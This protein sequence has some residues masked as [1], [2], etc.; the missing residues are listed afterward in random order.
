MA[1]RNT[2]LGGLDYQTTGAT[3]LNGALNSTS[4]SI[5]VTSAATFKT[6]GIVLVDAERITYVGRNATQFTGCT[7]GALGTSAASH[8]SGAGVSER[9]LI[10]SDDLNDTF[11]ALGTKINTLTMFWLNSS[12]YTVKEDFESYSVGN[13]FT[14]GNWTVT[15]GSTGTTKTATIASSTNSGGTGKELVLTTGDI[16]ASSATVTA[17]L[18][19]MTANKHKYIRVGYTLGGGAPGVP[20][21]SRITFK[22]GSSSADIVSMNTTTYATLP[23]TVPKTEIVVIAQGANVYDVYFN[24]VKVLS[25]VTQVTPSLTFEA[26]SDGESSSPVNA[27]AVMYI[28]DIRE[29]AGSV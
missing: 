2:L 13:F 20:T 18:A 28:D 27:T 29:S 21:M 23:A 25:G 1:I 4:T 17:V 16:T 26:F 11:D 14:G 7:R 6:S 19:G 15:T 5:T 24:Q 12:L 10:F 9:E 3:S 8:S 22:L